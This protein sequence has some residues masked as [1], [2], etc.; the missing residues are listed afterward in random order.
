MPS[1]SSAKVGRSVPPA[2]EALYS[3]PGYLYDTKVLAALEVV[4]DRR[5]LLDDSGTRIIH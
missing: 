3:C 5:G 1:T 2:L 4:L